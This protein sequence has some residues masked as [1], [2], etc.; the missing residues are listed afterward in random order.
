MKKQSP[1]KQ[2]GLDDPLDQMFLTLE[3]DEALDQLLDGGW[4]DLDLPGFDL[5]DL[6]ALDIGWPGIELSTDVHSIELDANPVSKSGAGKSRRRQVLG[7]GSQRRRGDNR[8]DNDKLC[9]ARS[10]IHLNF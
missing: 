8:R 2:L 10:Q 5:E 6:Q 3:H 7:T 9:G 1:K 4:G